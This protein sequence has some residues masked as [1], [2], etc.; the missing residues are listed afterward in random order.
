ML[1]EADAAT[2]SGSIGALLRREGLYSSH[3]TNWRRERNAGITQGL[4]P[5]TRGPKPRIDSSTKE[6]Q[7]LL[8]ENERLTERL[9]KAEIIID[10]QKKVAALLGRTLATPDPEDLL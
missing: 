6:V 1:A 10:V 9:R 7:R 8:R 4:T 3:L 5:R 2:D